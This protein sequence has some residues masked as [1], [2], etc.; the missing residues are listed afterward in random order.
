MA[1][2]RRG[3]LMDGSGV[4][5]ARVV[6]ATGHPAT[7]RHPAAA[8]VRAVGRVAAALFCLSVVFVPARAQTAAAGRYPQ[9]LALATFDSAWTRIRDTHYDTAFN[10]VDWGAVRSELR[11][12][13]A[14][15]Q[16]VGELR[17]V[18]REMLGRLGESH[19]GLI[20]GEAVSAIE[21][22]ARNRDD[23]SGPPGDLGLELRL[24]EG[25][26]AVLRVDPEGPAAAAGV[27]PGWLVRSI[28]EFEADPAIRDVL[29][30]E[31]EVAR[32]S[33][34]T[35]LL[36]GANTRLDGTAGVRLRIEFVDAK[37]RTTVL[38]LTRRARPGAPVRFGNLPTFFARLSH[39]RIGKGTDC[40]GLI[41]FNVWMVPLAP[42]FDRALDQLRGCRGIVIDLRG[43][44]GGVAGMVMGVAGHF[45]SEP[46]ALGTMRSRGTRLNFVANPRRVSA[47]AE[48]VEP[49]AGPLAVLIDPLSVSTS[50]IFAGGLQAVGRAHI[51]GENSAGQA[52]PATLLRLPN[53]DVLMHV[54]ADFTMPGGIRIEGRGVR[55][56][57]EA[58]L[59][60][61]DLLA[62]IDASLDAAVRW[63]R[64]TDGGARTENSHR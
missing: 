62:G 24:V 45:F 1:I 38:L 57:V 17:A 43:N 36:F 53:G 2:L 23:G 30:I 10:G 59:R 5:E 64:A 19:Y 41:R 28:A 22:G 56:D 55:P 13:A 14:G 7:E 44:P 21:S 39:E 46:V 31:D 58:P 4:V 47:S 40:V 48:I 6:T 29:S 8:A 16:S 12:R 27:R 35:Q 42:E 61:A 25:R 33:A 20:P 52:L 63:I 26:L 60:R 49:F 34:L 9:A 54:V 3:S 51:F 37:D 50:E 32:R 15:S 18:L 11:P